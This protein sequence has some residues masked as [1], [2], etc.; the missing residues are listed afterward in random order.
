M[1]LHQFLS[2]S[3]DLGLIWKPRWCIITHVIFR[4]LC[5]VL[6]V[7]QVNHF[8][9]A[10]HWNSFLSYCSSPVDKGDG[11]WPGEPQQ[12]CTYM[13]SHGLGQ[14][15]PWMTALAWLGFWESQSPFKPGQSHGFQAKPGQHNTICKIFNEDFHVK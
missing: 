9:T 4:V 1:P 10:K 3:H 14:A 8:K 7:W 11:D 12:S 6:D 13:Q 5:N 2:K 15:K